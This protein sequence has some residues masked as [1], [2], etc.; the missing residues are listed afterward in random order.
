MQNLEEG[1]A[2]YEDRDEDGSVRS[3]LYEYPRNVPMLIGRMG[4]HL[5]RDGAVP[6][7][8]LKAFGDNFGTRALNKR[9]LVTHMVR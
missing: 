6:Q 4:A 7:D 9:L 3:Y 8:L 2:W 1:L 5:V